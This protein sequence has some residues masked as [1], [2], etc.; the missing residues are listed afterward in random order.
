MS[1]VSF[2]RKKSHFL[3]NSGAVATITQPT[4]ILLSR[5]IAGFISN[6]DLGWIFSEVKYWPKYYPFKQLGT[7]LCAPDTMRWLHLLS[8]EV[9]GSLAW[10][11]FALMYE[12]LP[13]VQTASEGPGKYSCNETNMYDPNINVL[14]NRWYFLI[15]LRWCFTSQSTIFQSCWCIFLSSW[16]E[17]VLSRW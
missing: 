14:W 7:L 17:Q 2:Y 15:G 10:Y 1:F 12:H 13:R 4:K 16:V 11:M 9:R 6:N 5:Y 3:H 8:T